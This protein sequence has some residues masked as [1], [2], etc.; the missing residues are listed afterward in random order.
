MLLLA[1]STSAQPTAPAATTA[2]YDDPAAHFDP[3]NGFERI[4]FTPAEL[5]DKLAP[6]AGYVKFPGRPEQ[7][8]LSI[9][10]A[11]WDRGRSPFE[12]EFEQEMRGRIPDLLIKSKELTTL[13]NGMPAYWIKALAG[14]G[15]TASI[16]FAYVTVD[17][18]RGIAASIAGRVG[19]LTEEE[20]KDALKG[21]AVVVYPER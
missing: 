8:I 12:A 10:M 18:R 11:Q 2:T 3:Q 16:E 6:V 1:Q 7:R 19:E 9:E 13:S 14:E 17:G 4:Q 21:L 15:F 5:G 20:A